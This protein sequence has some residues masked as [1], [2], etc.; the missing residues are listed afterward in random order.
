M[1]VHRFTVPPDAPA[2]LDAFLVRMLPRASR[3]DVQRWLG[4]GRVT[5]NGK[6][7]R[8]LRRLFGGEAV[9]LTVADAPLPPPRGDLPTLPVL[10]ETSRWLVV[11]KPAGLVVE[12]DGDRPSVVAAVAQQRKA[13][14]GV[15]HRLDK[16][17]TGCLLLAKSD[18][19][20]RALFAAFEQKQIRKTYLALVL[21]EPPETGRLDTPYG[22][23]PDDPRRYT[24]KVSSPRRARLSWVK[25]SQHDGFAALEIDLDTGRTHQI[26][27][28]LS[29]VGFPLLGDWLYGTA[30][31][32]AKGPGRVALHAAKLD[33]EGQTVESPLPEDLR[34]LLC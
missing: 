16:D 13:V 30:E 20:M 1:P 6:K 10:L 29:D 32:K 28:Q 2:R 31:A 33:V 21:G 25:R 26:R 19:A 34:R 7:A 12:P 3:A 17:T 23:N 9:E 4:E 22:R 24:S 11:D 5:V 8:P 18:E 27:A 15:V 14:P